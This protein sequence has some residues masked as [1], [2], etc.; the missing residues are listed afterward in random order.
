MTELPP[1]GQMDEQGHRTYVC[2][3][4]VDGLPTMGEGYSA[5]PGRADSFAVCVHASE[6]KHLGGGVYEIAFTYTTKA[7]P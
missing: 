1:E 2:R 5:G 3:F 7:K 4:V 6:P